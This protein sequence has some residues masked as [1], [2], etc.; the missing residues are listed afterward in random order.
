MPL[1]VIGG[2]FRGR[3][4]K[5]PPAGVRPTSAI[6]RRSLF[7]ILGSRVVDTTVLDLYAGAGT[8]G[9]EALSRGAAGCD[10]VDRDR[11]CCDVLR[12]NLAAVLPA[13][14]AGRGRVH[15]A[16]AEVWLERNAAGLGEVDLVLID[17]PYGDA[18]LVRVLSRLASP[19]VLRATSLVVVEER[20]DRAIEAPGGLE[21]TR[22]VVHG[23]SALTMLRPSS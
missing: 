15:C 7:D 4:L 13:A 6:L 3:K 2:E 11:R 18:G 5:S 21:E 9:L 17:P 16:P 23:D 14:E 20:S 8:L 19:G 10:F 1:N 22:R 12:A